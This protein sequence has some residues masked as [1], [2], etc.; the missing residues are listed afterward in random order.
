V[1]TINTNDFTPENIGKALEQVSKGKKPVVESNESKE[2]PAEPAVAPAARTAAPAEEEPATEPEHP[3]APKISAG[4][5]SAMA[6]TIRRFPAYLS[7]YPGGQTTE[8]TMQSFGPTTVG[9]YEFL[10]SDEPE[11]V[12]SYYEKKFT[13]AG[14]TIAASNTGSNDNGAT[15][16]LVATTADNRGNVTLNAETQAGGKAKVTIG[17]TSAKP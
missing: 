16:M 17:F 8:A 5:A 1:V 4:K 3:A 12:S 11:A 9:T 2:A 13:T 7:T 14:L 15:A 6:A 10:T